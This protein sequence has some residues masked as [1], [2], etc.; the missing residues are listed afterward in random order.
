MLNRL[1]GFYKMS[2][3]FGLDMGRK[4]GSIMICKIIEYND[5]SVV[6]FG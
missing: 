5:L 6:N 4:N 3:L 1:T 2:S